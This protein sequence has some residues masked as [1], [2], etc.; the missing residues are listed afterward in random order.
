[1]V[2]PDKFVN[3]PTLMSG[4]PGH[5]IIQTNAPGGQMVVRY[6]VPETPGNEATNLP[7]KIAVAL[8][9]DAKDPQALAQL[10][11]LKDLRTNPT[12]PESDLYQRY[13]RRYNGDEEKAIEAVMQFKEEAARR[14]KLAAE[15]AAVAVRGSPEAA[16]AAGNVAAGTAT[17]R[18]QAT[19]AAEEGLP[20]NEKA[21]QWVNRKTLEYA[22]AE[23]TP[24]EAKAGDYA[25]VAP[26]IS[27]AIPAARLALRTLDRYREL[28]DKLLVSTEKV[29]PVSGKTVK[30][31]Q[32]EIVSD[33]KANQLKMQYWST[34]DPDVQEFQSLQATV[35]SHV[36]AFMDTGAIAVK[37]Q[38]F[39]IKALPNDNDS[40]ESALRKVD[41]R[42]TLLESIVRGALSGQSRMA[43]PPAAP[44]PSRSVSDPAA[45]DW[46]KKNYPSAR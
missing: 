29:D 32:S 22:P 2:G 35:A 11:I 45:Q 18:V 5:P 4:T 23:M 34:G 27:A 21:S 9:K 36:K 3:K 13:L 37:E 8:A 19:S 43:G 25:S 41:S 28:A 7:N 15:R 39:Q 24:K 12:A 40:V 16:Q 38:E 14:A 30:K 17:G 44:I 42:K 33:I 10:Q 46:L 6:T 1:M 26:R 31:S 20:L